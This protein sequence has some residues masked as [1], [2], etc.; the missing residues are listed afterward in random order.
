MNTPNT[1]FYTFARKAEFCIAEYNKVKNN[2]ITFNNAK[3]FR[4]TFVKLLGEIEVFGIDMDSDEWV[5]YELL[6]ERLREELKGAVRLVAEISEMNLPEDAEVVVRSSKQTLAEFISRSIGQI[7]DAAVAE[8]YSLNEIREALEDEVNCV[9]DTVFP[10]G[11]E[12][13]DYDEE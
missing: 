10:M 7:V 5:D 6:K 8:G 1:P 12:E 13:D 9:C 4:E 2:G 3:N 11:T